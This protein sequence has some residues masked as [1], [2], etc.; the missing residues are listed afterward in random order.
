[1]AFGMRGQMIG[2]TTA[3]GSGAFAGAAATVPNVPIGT[4]Q[5]HA[6][7]LSSNATAVEYFYVGDFFPQVTPSV[8][9][10]LPADV[11]DFSGIESS[12]CRN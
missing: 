5:L 10:L 3:D 9:Y 6:F 1:M 4:Y 8:Y 11:I 7:G 2:Q 12:A